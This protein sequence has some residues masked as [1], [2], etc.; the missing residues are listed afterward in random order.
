MAERAF[1]AGMKHASLLLPT[2]D[3]MLAEAGRAVGDVRAV[4][5][6]AGPGSFTG[7]RVAVTFAK[8]LAF[9][10]GVKLVAVPSLRVAVENAPAAAGRVL[11]VLDAR[12][13]QV[14]AA[15]YERQ[16]KGFAEVRG[17]HLTSLANALAEATDAGTPDAGPL[18]LLGEGLAYHLP[19]E[20]PA[21]VCVAPENLW[22]PRA[23]ALARVAAGEAA[24]GRFADPFELKPIYVRLAEAHEKRLM[25][26]HGLAEPPTE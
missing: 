5:I 25:R 3:A 17:V 20:V 23:A 4:Y 14:F 6:S 7:L 2:V 26:E 1:P 13:G 15:T 19:G 9:A 24:A 10:R 21:G 16:G 12:R 8:T 18:W 22:R 11:G